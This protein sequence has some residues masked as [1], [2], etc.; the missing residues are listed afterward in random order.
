MMA[1]L[2]GSSTSFVHSGLT[3][4]DTYKY[5]GRTVPAA[6]AKSTWAQQVEATVSNIPTLTAHG[7]IGQI[8]LDWTGVSGAGSYHL[9][10]WKER[11]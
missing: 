4:G 6:G 10:M 8:E 7:T 2:T 3:S 5:T 1:L 11:P 9:I